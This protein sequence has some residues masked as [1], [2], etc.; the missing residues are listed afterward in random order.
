MGTPTV[1]LGFGRLDRALPIDGQLE[2]LA[3]AIRNLESWF[4]PIRH[5]LHDLRREIESVRTMAQS[6]AA[7]ALANIEDKVKK[8]T[9]E[10]NANQTLDVRWAIV[11]LFISALGTGLQYLA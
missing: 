7:I 10:L 2:Q 8:L 9:V 1:L 11:G 5:D 4:V 3:V 6:S